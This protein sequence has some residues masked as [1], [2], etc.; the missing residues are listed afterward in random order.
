MQ[1][2]PN[3][4]LSIIPIVM[5]AL[6]LRVESAWPQNAIQQ[7]RP[8][9]KAV[10]PSL[11]AAP[12]PLLARRVAVLTPA[13]LA[14]VSAQTQERADQTAQRLMASRPKGRKRGRGRSRRPNSPAAARSNVSSSNTAV[15]ATGAT[16]A[17]NQTAAGASSGTSAAAAR[18]VQGARKTESGTLENTGASGAKTK[19]PPSANSTSK[20]RAGEIVPPD[21]QNALAQTLLSDLIAERLRDR[22]GLAVVPDAEGRAALA[23]LHLTAA[24]LEDPARS[25]DAR[26]LCALLHCQALLIPR[27]TRCAVSDRLTR[28]VGV[29]AR[30]TI[31][32]LPAAFVPGLPAGTDNVP[33]A[34]QDGEGVDAKR[35]PMRLDIAGGAASERVLFHSRYQKPQSDLIRDAAAQ[36]AN[37]LTHALQSGET[38]PLMRPDDRLATPPVLAPTQADKLVFTTR[39]RRVYPAAARN[40]RGDV[41]VLWTPDLLPLLPDNIVGASRVRQAL[42]QEAHAE[43]YLWKDAYQPDIAR[44]QALARRLGVAYMLLARVTDVE[45]S[46]GAADTSVLAIAEQPNPGNSIPERSARAEALALLVRASDGSVLWRERATSTMTTSPGGG[47]A[48]QSDADL[49]RDAS[50]FALVDLGRRFRHWRADFEK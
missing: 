47:T 6:T 11:Q 26:R 49:A 13:P 9:E 14:A 48:S 50:H 32:T 1:P 20:S 18:E 30:V 24:D 41:S 7:A 19:T 16:Q 40:L 15:S 29:W 10:S 27:L 34:R 36:S 46:Q 4:H 33:A 38:A 28:A 17:V 35:W 42:A 23:A 3:K 39:G 44:I 37:L 43:T 12:A 2:N 8:P 45:L 22:L 21:Q 25:G 5:A 31:Q